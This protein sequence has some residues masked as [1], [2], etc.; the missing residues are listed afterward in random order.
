M[1]VGND[2]LKASKEAVNSIFAARAPSTNLFQKFKD[3]TKSAPKGTTSG[4]RNQINRTSD[5]KFVDDNFHHIWDYFCKIRDEIVKILKRCG[6]YTL[7]IRFYRILHAEAESCRENGL[8]TKENQLQFFKVA[9]Q[10]FNDVSGNHAAIFEK[11]L[12]DDISGIILNSYLENLS[13]IPRELREDLVGDESD[14]DH[15]N[16]ILN[17]VNRN[18]ELTGTQESLLGP[19]YWLALRRVASEKENSAVK[20]HSLLAKIDEW[21]AHGAACVSG[22]LSPNVVRQKKEGVLRNF[23]QVI[24]SIEELLSQ[25]NQRLGGL[26][27]KLVYYKYRQKINCEQ[28]IHVPRGSPNDPDSYISQE[29]I[30]QLSKKRYP[31]RIGAVSYTHLTLPTILLV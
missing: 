14:V 31:Y 30:D 23:E 5:G 20:N 22:I 1:L 27:G 26:S 13:V 15:Y 21:L 9:L 8:I 16:T 25:S 10:H 11:D 3:A 29:I 7:I 2:R 24:W 6:E 18:I 12:F 19:L 4:Q 17:F 28:E